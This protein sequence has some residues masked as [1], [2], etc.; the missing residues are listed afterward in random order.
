[1]FLVGVFCFGLAALFN[2]AAA[3]EEGDEVPPPVVLVSE[4]GESEAAARLRIVSQ[5]MFV[6]PGSSP[7]KG[8][9]TLN[10]PG[11]VFIPDPA[12]RF[13]PGGVVTG[14][15]RTAEGA[16]AQ[17]AAVEEAVL[18]TMCLDVAKAIHAGWV[19]ESGPEFAQWEQAQNVQ[20]FLEQ[21][22]ATRCKEP[23]VSVVFDPA[24]GIV[25]GEVGDDWVAVCVL[26]SVQA[27]SGGESQTMGYG[28]CSGMRW[29]QDRWM[30]GE[31]AARAPSMLP[32][33]VQAVL[34]G[35]LDWVPVAEGD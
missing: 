15:P 22:G 3:L 35:W 24:A 29:H 8:D 2:P 32:G 23:G 16:L 34:A 11:Q 25:K 31:I 33:S 12:D 27:Q 14:F 19:D 13:G 6:P 28:Y 9:P 5:E 4:A 30:L 17:L 10:E 18:E 21:A 20:A 7:F 26:A 1:V